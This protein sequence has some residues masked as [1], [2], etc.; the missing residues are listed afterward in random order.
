[1]LDVCAGKANMLMM[2]N[3]VS[4]LLDLVADAFHLAGQIKVAVFSGR[5]ALKG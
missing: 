3:L 1:M 4:R 5:H 2:Y